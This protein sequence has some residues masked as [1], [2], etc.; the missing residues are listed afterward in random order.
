VTLFSPVASRHV[1]SH[2]IVVALHRMAL[3]I[4]AVRQVVKRFEL[5]LDPRKEFKGLIPYVLL[6]DESTDERQ[7][8]HRLWFQFTESVNIL[9]KTR[10]NI[11]VNKHMRKAV[12]DS[13]MENLCKG[14]SR[15]HLHLKVEFINRDHKHYKLELVRLSNVPEGALNC[16]GMTAEIPQPFYEVDAEL[17]GDEEETSQT[18]DADCAN[19][20][21]L[22]QSRPGA[23]TARIISS[24]TVETIQAITVQPDADFPPF[25]FQVVRI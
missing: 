17:I 18:L 16:Q 5:E 1:P 11:L 12:F 21:T 13:G 6:Q 19:A 10:Q 25:A 20:H 15:R 7:R 9:C 22:Y 8:I 14:F 2:V 23:Q 3:I 4:M 24:S